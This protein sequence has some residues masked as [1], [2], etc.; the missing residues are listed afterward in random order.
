MGA[1]A[2]FR[3]RTATPCAVPGLASWSPPRR[4]PAAAR[5]PPAAAALP[6]VR[7][8][9]T[10]IR[11][12]S[13]NHRPRHFPLSLGVT[14][15]MPRSRAVPPRPRRPPAACRP[16][17]APGPGRPKCVRIPAAPRARRAAPRSPLCQ[18]SLPFPFLSCARCA[19]GATRSRGGAWTCRRRRC[20]F[21][22]SDRSRA[23]FDVRRPFKL[24]ISAL[25]TYVPVILVTTQHEK[26][27]GQQKRYVSFL[28]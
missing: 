9:P 20:D 8:A 25:P 21:G 28:S 7:A 18:H 6:R 10:R 11:L 19:Q 17:R 15:G 23:A 16:S 27:V 13:D 26:Q 12:R 3:P 2:A 14:E 4:H 22:E 5:C 24:N 1:I